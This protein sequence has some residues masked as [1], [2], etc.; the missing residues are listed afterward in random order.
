MLRIK[1]FMCTKTKVGDGALLEPRSKF[2]VCEEDPFT[3]IFFFYNAL[4]DEY[5][6]KGQFHLH[7][8]IYRSIS[9][10]PL[11]KI[12]SAGR[13]FWRN[14]PKVDVAMPSNLKWMRTGFNVD[15]LQMRKK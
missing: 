6:F 14:M 10:F 5:I 3:H 4:L 7:K 1:N 13:I 12:I 15:I 2:C 9:S 8:P 11:F